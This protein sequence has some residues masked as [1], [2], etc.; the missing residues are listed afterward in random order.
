MRL[1]RSIYAL[2]IIRTP[3]HCV[4]L[5]APSFGILC[6]PT[7]STGDATALVWR[8]MRSY[9]AHL[10]VLHFSW[11]PC[12]RRENAALVCDRCFTDTM[13]RWYG[14]RTVIVQSSLNRTTSA[15]RNRTMPVL[16]PCGFPAIV[17]RA[18]DHFWAQII[19]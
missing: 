19:I 11:T 8:C 14:K 17:L 1:W 5:C 6:N 7:A 10:R 15:H 16:C 12:D 9:S 13:W 2:I 18:Y 3:S 4:C